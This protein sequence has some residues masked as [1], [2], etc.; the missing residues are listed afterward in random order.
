MGFLDGE[1]G[2]VGAPS[3]SLTRYSIPRVGGEEPLLDDRDIL[4]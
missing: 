3:S 1:M 4:V 2:M